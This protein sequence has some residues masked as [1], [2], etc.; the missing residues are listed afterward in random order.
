[1]DTT[2]GNVPATDEKM[3]DKRNIEHAEGA[4]EFE[5]GEDGEEEYYSEGSYDDDDDDDE[6]E[7]EEE[8][9]D[10]EEMQ[11]M[12]QLMATIK[13]EKAENERLARSIVGMAVE[14]KKKEQAQQQ[15]AGTGDNQFPE[16]SS[17]GKKVPMIRKHQ[18]MFGQIM[19]LA[20]P[21]G[22]GKND[23]RDNKDNDEAGDNDNDKKPAFKK[24]S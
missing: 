21:S 13:E 5:H 10:E 4:E 11:V 15:E 1:M 12:M 7:E 3:E 24:E 14:Q 22:D 8:E 23:H 9:Y 17:P 6:D 20:Q 19:K 18:T 16:P 2:G